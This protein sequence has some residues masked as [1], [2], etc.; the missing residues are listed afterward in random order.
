M[1]YSNKKLLLDYIHA[2]KN[3]IEIDLSF[4]SMAKENGSSIGYFPR[5][6][7][8]LVKAK[9]NRKIS[10]FVYLILRYL[11]L[12]GGGVLY[13]FKDFCKFALMKFNNRKQEKV[14]F[15]DG[16]GDGDGAVLA[17]CSRASCVID[18]RS[19]KDMPKQWLVLPWVDRSKLPSDA[20]PVQL[21]TV[22]NVGDLA[23]SLIDAIRSIYIHVKYY[24]NLDWIL[25]TYTAFKWFLVRRVVDRLTGRLVIVEHFDRWAVL[26][27]RSVKA[28]R[29]LNN[30]KLFSIVQH[31]T[32]RGLFDDA[33]VIFDMAPYPTLL[34]NVNELY[35]YNKVEENIFKRKILSPKI[36]NLIAIKYFNPPIIL[37]DCSMVKKKKLL[38]VGHPLCEEFQ[39]L[40]YKQLIAQIDVEVFYKPHPK[41]TKSADICEVGWTVIEDASLFPSVDL[42]VSY[43]S[44]LVVEYSG[45][46][47]QACIHPINAEP[48][49]LEN[50]VFHIWDSFRDVRS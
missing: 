48:N 6:P 35:V 14:S 43:P 18:S 33:E 39:I 45:V 22:V 1:N 10:W 8:W 38:F 3:E 20:I 47:V 23:S 4:F 41:S 13:F 24:N 42:L 29:R 27:D 19:M 5:V 49:L 26:V 50:F 11:W 16:D 31:G 37:T 12:C 17:F 46:G 28:S 32:L 7:L 25:Q 15:G 2:T 44:T 30:S 9:D 34:F 21:M 40:V 36:K